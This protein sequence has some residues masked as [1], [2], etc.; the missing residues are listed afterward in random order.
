[1]AKYSEPIPNFRIFAPSK[2][3]D[4]PLAT[5][6]PAALSGLSKGLYSFLCALATPRSHRSLRSRRNDGCRPCG[7]ERGIWAAGRAMGLHGTVRA[8]HIPFLRSGTPHRHSATPPAVRGHGQPQP[9]GGIS[10]NTYAMTKLSHLLR[11]RKGLRNGSKLLW[12]KVL[13]LRFECMAERGPDGFEISVAFSV[14]LLC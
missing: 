11:Q 14:C 5:I 10:N 2:I 12:L 6:L 7:G 3:T 4:E 8:A 13:L 9:C 1:M